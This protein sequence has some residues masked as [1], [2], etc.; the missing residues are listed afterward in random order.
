MIGARSI[1]DGAIYD[2][3]HVITARRN[4]WLIQHPKPGNAML[5]ASSFCVDAVMLFVLL[6]AVLGP[7]FTPFWGLFGL[8]ALR[9]LSQASVALPVPQGIIWR[10][11]GFPSF[12][13]AILR[14][15]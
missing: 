12:F 6:Y 4:A 10:D 13:D 9:Q 2:H 8:F 5:I 3:L 11:P 7:S 1:A 14:P 15:Q